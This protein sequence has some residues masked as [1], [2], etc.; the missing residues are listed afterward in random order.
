MSVTI[1]SNVIV[2]LLAGGS[3]KN[4]PFVFHFFGDQKFEDSS[5]ILIVMIKGY[6]TPWS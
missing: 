1:Y 3:E 5:R 6:F 4:H 2:S